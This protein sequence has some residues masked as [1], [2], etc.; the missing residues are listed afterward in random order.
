[1]YPST[2]ITSF[3]IALTGLG[4]VSAVP[5]NVVDSNVG[6]GPV[7]VGNVGGGNAQGSNF[8]G[9]NLGA[10]VVGAATSKLNQRL[11]RTPKKAKELP[12]YINSPQASNEGSCNGKGYNS[13]LVSL[14]ENASE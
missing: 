4:P 9:S 3:L 14:S 2:L 7:G 5:T 13:T 11:R 10:V 8:A 1:M 12:Q 6:A